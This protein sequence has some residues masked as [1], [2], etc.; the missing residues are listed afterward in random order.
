[1]SSEASHISRWAELLLEGDHRALPRL[2]W[3]GE[4]SR[5]LLKVK[6]SS[7]VASTVAC[8]L[9]GPDVDL[10]HHFWRSQQWSGEALPGHG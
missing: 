10:N 6:L 9:Q 7:S 1:M 2:T 3:T 4:T 8:R 5:T